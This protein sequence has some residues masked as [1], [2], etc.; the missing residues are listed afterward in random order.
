L[1]KAGEKIKGQRESSKIVGCQLD[2]DKTNQLQQLATACQVTVNTVIQ[3]VWGVLLSH[4]N[5]AEDV[6]FGAAVSGRPTD[7]P[8][9]EEMLGLFLN[10]VPVRVQADG[11]QRFDELVKK[12]QADSLA[13][14]PHHYYSL[15]EIQTASEAKQDLL[16]HVFIFQN[17]P[18]SEELH[19]IQKEFNIDFSIDVSEIF[20]QTNYDLSIEVNPGK[21]MGID[22]RYNTLVFQEK[23]MTTIAEQVAQ[24]I[25]G[26]IRRP[27]MTI[28]EI[29]A[30][31]VSEAEKEEHADFLNA[32]MTIDD[33]F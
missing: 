22:L 15:A 19:N 9:V 4:Y 27:D 11:M 31:L 8:G 32:T 1:P 16:D 2:E 30:S 23:L 6:V 20:E 10:T 12:V 25:D 13:G 26:V 14:E 29:K 28:S 24:M 3:T 21:E 18:F 33:D 7:I 17:F 5:G